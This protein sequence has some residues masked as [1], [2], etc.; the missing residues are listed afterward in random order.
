MTKK[1]YKLI[2]DVLLKLLNDGE[3]NQIDGIA[4][5]EKTA[6]NLIETFK[7]DNPKFSEDK[8]LKAIKLTKI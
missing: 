3:N 6:R 4:G 8:F 5:I 1:D 2:A 7:K